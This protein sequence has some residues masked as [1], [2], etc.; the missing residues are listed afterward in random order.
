MGFKK[1]V[2][3]YFW[4]TAFFGW[5]VLLIILSVIPTSSLI[6]TEENKLSSFRLDYLIHF[7]VFFVFSVLYGFWRLKGPAQNKRQ[8]LLLF[9]ATGTLYAIATELLQHFVEGRSVNP[10]D[11]LLNMAGLYA[12]TTIFYFIFN[13]KSRL[14]G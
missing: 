10:L 14:Y 13:K 12:G 4:M 3:R 11:A 1:L 9:L 8:E 5:A 6:E 7:G 2:E